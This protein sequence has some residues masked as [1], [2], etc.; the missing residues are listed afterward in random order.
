MFGNIG[1]LSNAD[2]KSVRRTP[3]K[4]I[5]STEEIATKTDEIRG[6]RIK[7]IRNILAGGQQIIWRKKLI[8]NKPRR[9]VTGL[10]NERIAH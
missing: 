5:I 9:G 2:L 6:A 10:P 4:L 1:R 7:K 8:E 3:G